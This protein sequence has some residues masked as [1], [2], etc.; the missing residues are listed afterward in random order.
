MA[1]ASQGE[2]GSGHIGHDVADEGSNKVRDKGIFMLIV[3][4]GLGA[5][6]LDRIFLGN[7]CCGIAKML[8]LGGMGIWAL[9]DIIAELVNA[10]KAEEN[11]DTLSMEAT[12]VPD[13]IQTA[14]SLGHCALVLLIVSAV[15]CLLNSCFGLFGGIAAFMSRRKAAAPVPVATAA[16]PMMQPAPPMAT[17]AVP[18]ATAAVP[19]ATTTFA[20]P[21]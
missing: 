3:L 8:T 17:A 2:S 6:G 12:W 21:Y 1:S 13:S 20:R 5:L 19:M 10:L 4:T 15:C 9:I 14:K 7:C 18:M 11:I 16:V